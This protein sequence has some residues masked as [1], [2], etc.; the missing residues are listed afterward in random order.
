MKFLQKLS[1]VLYTYLIRFIGLFIK[2]NEK[3]ILFGSWGG[4][5]YID[6]TR[7]MFEYMK[8]NYPGYTLIWI[9]RP[10]IKPLI[11]SGVSIIFCHKNSLKSIYY[12]LKSRYAFLTHG[13][14]DL[15]PTN[16][17]S[18]TVLIWFDHGVPL[19]KWELDA[20]GKPEV[21]HSAMR[22]H[23]SKIYRSLLGKLPQ[24]NYFASASPLND[25]CLLTAMKMFGSEK[26]VIMKTGTPRNDMLMS[27]SET[28]KDKLKEKYSKLLG[29]DSN[30]K[31]I[32]YAPTFRRSNS[33]VETFCE[34]EHTDHDKILD[35]LKKYNAV[36]LEKNHFMTCKK[37]SISGRNEE[38]ILI[39][40]GGDYRINIQEML[41]F[42]D[43]LISDY[44][45]VMLDFVL[46]NR[47]MICWVYD[48]EFYRDIDSGLY[49][50]IED[51]AP[52]YVT[53][54]Y[55]DTCTKLEKILSGI[56]LH[57]EKRS[58]VREKYMTYEKGNA[59]EQTYNI[60]FGK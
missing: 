15:F 6:N 37:N 2:K 19:K 47:P 8:D 41:T 31:I 29:F 38:E 55:E 51:Y 35:L 4:A 11:P 44:S 43:I 33:M 23:L 56:D 18:G 13:I 28:E 16:I 24:Y 30:K 58:Y 42:T 52:G 12:I 10:P 21:I 27:I 1:R 3:Y 7:Y 25:A 57:P 45:S 60:V 50:D 14:R 59:C 49:Y 36:L 39:K 17:F 9:G 54:T 40:I 46:L 20:I 26:A 5:S 53:V 48:Y 32:L 34:R 22:R